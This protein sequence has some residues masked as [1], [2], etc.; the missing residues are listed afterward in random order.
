MPLPLALGLMAGGNAI[1]AAAGGISSYMASQ[2]QQKAAREARG[3]IQDYTRQATD[4]QRPYYD[5]GTRNLQGLDERMAA[6]Y[7]DM[8]ETMYQQPT[9]NFEQDPGYQFRMQQGTTAINQSAAAQGQSLSSA[10]QKALAKYGQGQASNEYQRA[11]DRFGQDRAFDY[12]VFGDAYNRQAAEK[13]ARWNRGTG[14]ANVGINA[15]NQM[16]SYASQAG[17]DVAATTIGGGNAQAAGIMGVGQAFGNVGQN[18]ASAGRIP[19]A[20]YIYGKTGYA[21]DIS[22]QSAGRPYYS[23]D[24]YRSLG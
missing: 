4:F 5:V 24:L 22:Q 21:P 13:Q 17:R 14:L 10:T 7:Y 6:G 2:A 11:Y 9:F 15:A 18:I 19:L 20:G 16:G 1:D 12:S 3:Q 23:D 8:P